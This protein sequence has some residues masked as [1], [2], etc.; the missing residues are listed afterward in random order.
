MLKS[1]IH[2]VIV[3][4]MV[5]LNYSC[6]NATPDMDKRANDKKAAEEQ[7]NSKFD[8][9]G[10]QDASY[11][12]DI[13]A[14][15]LYE[16]EFAA[17]AKEM[18]SRQDVKALSDTVITIHN[19]IT[20]SMKELAEKKGITLPLQLDQDK[21]DEIRKTVEKEKEYF[22]QYFT[23]KVVTD[24]KDILKLFQKASDDANDAGISN[25]FSSRQEQLKILLTRALQTRERL[26]E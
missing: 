20:D 26:K 21:V 24:H 12:V 5:R 8:R 14:R 15:E 18:A 7:N 16:M 22:D 13:Y 1:F 3:V 25:F 11:V 9:I 19:L 2:L 6:T 17:C 23:D 4:M 10:K